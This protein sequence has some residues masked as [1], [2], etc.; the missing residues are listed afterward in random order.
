ME[1]DL[2]TCKECNVHK[3]IG[4][5]YKGIS[6]KWIDNKYQ[7]FVI[8]KDCIKKE[9]LSEY[10]KV[11]NDF[12]QAL[13]IMCTK[14]NIYYDEN[15][16]NYV[17]KNIVN[18]NWTLFQGYIKCISS[19]AQYN[20]LKYKDSVW[21]NNNT[22]ISNYLDILIPVEEKS[23]IDFINDDIKQL[24]KNIEKTIQKE[25]FNAHNKWMNCLRDALELREKLQEHNN[26]TKNFNVLFTL[27]NI[28][29]TSNVFQCKVHLSHR[30]SVI[31]EGTLDDLS[32]LFLNDICENN[33]KNVTIYHCGS[34]DECNLASKLYN[35]GCKTRIINELL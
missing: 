14:Y 30:G 15:L 31:Y 12:R 11:H 24:K 18:D 29:Q 25:D 4:K 5:F 2:I 22:S 26:T 16:M 13:V 6:E 8:C 21:K 23:D 20:G 35:L 28:N 1:I 32:E 27:K 10:K 17:K 33:N 7:P 19:L 3:G 9:Y 34:N